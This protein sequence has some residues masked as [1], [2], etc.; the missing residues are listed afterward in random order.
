[1]TIECVTPSPWRF[2]GGLLV[3]GALVLLG[4]TGAAVGSDIG[5]LPWNESNIQTLRSYDKSSIEA[6]VNDLRGGD[7][8]HALVGGFGW[9]DLA[10]DHRY[11]LVAT[12]DLSGRAL[13][14]YL[15]IY[16][17]D[18][19]GKPIVQQWIEGERIGTDMSRV[20]RDLNGDGKRELIIPKMLVS[21]STAET[22]TW[23]T[24]YRLQHGKYVEASHDFAAFYDK[25]VL[26]RIDARIES[27]TTATGSQPPDVAVLTME[28][29]KVLRVLGRDPTA[30]LQQAYQWMNSDDPRL[31]QDAAATF[32]DIGGHERE[33]RELLQ[34][35]PAAEK[36]EM[37]SRGGG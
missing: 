11:E 28:R 34:A 20:V 36:R 1:M 10:G 31:L 2:A 9:Y 32:Q 18:N 22:F 26:P 4:L 6:F 37:E 19:A 8:L 21:Y 30:G 27:Q 24:V 29:D 13:F 33:V 35:L 17:Q 15:A 12:E 23:P 25:E 5:D 7:L 14:D 3:I 16:E